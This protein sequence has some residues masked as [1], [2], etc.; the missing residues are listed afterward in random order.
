MALDRENNTQLSAVLF[1]D[2]DDFKNGVGKAFVIRRLV[3][4]A[5]AIK[6]NIIH[7]L[8]HGQNHGV[9]IRYHAARACQA[10]ALDAVNVR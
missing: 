3:F 6:G 8:A 10:D 1:N 9:D 5:A 2:A 4:I 7:I